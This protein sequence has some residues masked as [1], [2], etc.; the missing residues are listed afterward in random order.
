MASGQALIYSLMLTYD[1]ILIYVHT[2]PL[3]LNPSISWLILDVLP[4]WISCR[5]LKRFN[6][7]LPRPLSNSSCVKT[8]SN[9]L[10]PASTFPSTASRMSM[11]WK[12]IN[13]MI[14]E[15]RWN[16]TFIDA[17]I[18]N[19]YN[20]TPQFQWVLIWLQSSSFKRGVHIIC[21]YLFLGTEYSRSLAY[22]GVSCRS[23]DG[24]IPKI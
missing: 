10:F 5:C 13:Q 7:A 2:S 4:V 14:V 17:Y 18:V 24:S 11:N 20:V 3:L 19:L 23:T 9:V 22:I 21:D 16:T 1:S 15:R 12:D 6:L 8:P